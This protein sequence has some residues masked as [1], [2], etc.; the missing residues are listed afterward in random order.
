MHATRR[1]FPGGCRVYGIP[2]ARNERRRDMG[3]PVGRAVRL[4]SA[5]L[6]AWSAAV[7]TG[8]CAE[9]GPGPAGRE[10]MSARRPIA[11]VL[12]ENAGR[13][14]EIDGVVGVYEGRLDEGGEC[15]TVMV[16][17]NRPGL[18]RDIPS[19]IG[20]YPVRLEIGGEIRPMR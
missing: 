3:E 14:M 7:S 12:K 9:E 11:E 20:G 18:E 17:S 16:K 19:S 5:I 15:I 1:E 2:A 13:L 8:G 10:E 4:L 6:V